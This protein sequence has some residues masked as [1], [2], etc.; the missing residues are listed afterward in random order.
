MLNDI[1]TTWP[2]NKGHLFAVDSMGLFSFTLHSKRQKYL[3]RIRWCVTV[4]Q[5]HHRNWYQ[6]VPRLCEFLSFSH[7]NYMPIFYRFWDV[8]NYCRKSPF[9]PLQSRFK[10]SQRGPLECRVW[11][12][13]QT[14]VPGLSAGENHVITWAFVFTRYRFVT[15]GRTDGQ[16]DG[17]RRSC[18]S[19]AIAK[20]SATN[21]DDGT[22]SSE[23]LLTATV[24][25]TVHVGL[26]IQQPPRQP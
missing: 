4:F 3:Y 17:R 15:D 7:C 10:V 5:D 13:F 16:T 1:M 20:L 24:S 11:N 26:H 2:W 9:F 6:S 19:R 12:L 23:K 21:N 14:R 18:V 25:S 22:L 8:S